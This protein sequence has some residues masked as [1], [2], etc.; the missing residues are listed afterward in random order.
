MIAFLRFQND[1]YFF[2]F[3]DIVWIIFFLDLF[4]YPCQKMFVKNM[5]NMRRTCYIYWVLPQNS[6]FGFFFFLLVQKK[7]FLH[8]SYKEDLQ[9]VHFSE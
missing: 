3:W 9:N 2:S 7:H 1:G 8:T 4:I 6:F 5:F